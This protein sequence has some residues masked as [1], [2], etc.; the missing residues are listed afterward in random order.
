MKDS[1]TSLIFGSEPKIVPRSGKATRFACKLSF[2]LFSGSKAPLIYF[3][4]VFGVVFFLSFKLE[5]LRD[6]GSST[7]ICFW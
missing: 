4:Q 3:M 1:N 7:F 5:S 6:V 2:H